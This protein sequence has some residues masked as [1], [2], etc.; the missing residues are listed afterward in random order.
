MGWIEDWPLEA[1]APES[2][3][4]E[5]Q[6]TLTRCPGGRDLARIRVGLIEP[7]QRIAGALQQ[8]GRGGH[9]SSTDD[10]EDLSSSL[11]SSSA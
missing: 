6:T 4:P 3:P 2:W 8:Q 9:P 11:H 1:A 10:G 7:E 5:Y